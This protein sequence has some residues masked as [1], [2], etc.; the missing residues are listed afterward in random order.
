[1]PAASEKPLTVC[2]FG[3]YRENYSRNQMMM[4]GLRMNGVTVKDCHETLWHGIEDRVRVASGAWKEPGFWRRFIVAYWHLLKKYLKIGDYDVMV[5]GYPGQFDVLLARVL[6][7]LN[8]KP[9]AWD[10]FMSIYLITIERGL[11][12]QS[13]LSAGMLKFIERLA[14]K[15][16]NRLILDTSQ[17]EAWFT[18]TYWMKAERFRLVPTG[19]DDRIFSPQT[20]VLAGDGTCKV[21]YYG[22]FIPNH[23]VMYM[24]E[25]AKI[26]ASHAEIRFELIGS[27]P[28][29]EKAKEYVANQELANV[30]FIEWMDKQELKM[31][32]QQADICLGAFGTTPQSM[33]T[34]QNKI[35]EA[36]AMRKALVSGDSPAIRQAFTHGQDIYLCERANGQALAEAILILWKNPLM[37]GQIA[38][39]GYVLYQEQYCL[40][41]NGK[42]FKNY[43]IGLLQ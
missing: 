37:R 30:E 19:A 26:L 23:G 16:P 21:L 10:I 3:T 33:M 18:H 17:Y 27:G 5:V 32:I 15:L 8:R 11:D 14:L 25:A 9:L 24:V 4:A 1:M 22:T 40:L 13:K 36:A 28:E 34:I 41:I 35:Y 31:H 43:L 29:L 12:Q 20:D 7:W 2:Y 6:T 38:Q 39:A 42:R